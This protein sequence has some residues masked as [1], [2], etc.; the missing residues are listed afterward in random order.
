MDG[1]ID[2]DGQVSRLRELVKGQTTNIYSFDLS[3]ATDRLPVKVQRDILSLLFRD[4]R[5][6]EL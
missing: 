6:A 3:A 4:E 2:Q 5:I 1:T